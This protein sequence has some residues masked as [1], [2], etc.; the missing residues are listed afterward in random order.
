MMSEKEFTRLL[1][2]IQA[3]VKSSNGWFNVSFEAYKLQVLKDKS[4][5]W[6]DD[7]DSENDLLVELFE[8]ARKRL[9][10][11]VRNTSLAYGDYERVKALEMFNEVPWPST[12]EDLL[13]SISELFL[14]SLGD[15]LQ[16]N[17]VIIFLVTSRA[18]RTDSGRWHVRDRLCLLYRLLQPTM[19]RRFGGTQFSL[20]T[21]KELFLM[22][23][24]SFYKILCDDGLSDH[25]PEIRQLLY[26][27]WFMLPDLLLSRTYKKSLDS[28]F[29]LWPMQVLADQRLEAKKRS[30]SAYTQWPNL[31]LSQ[32]I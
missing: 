16:R 26:E 5:G 18:L 10:V 25:D 22:W 12:G 29:K 11:V 24:S 15:H 3:C 19:Y 7:S 4:H 31:L 9:E 2:H 17:C 27:A 13:D 1:G 21:E 32:K 30:L 6:I 8:L 20:K 23:C 28:T 14:Q